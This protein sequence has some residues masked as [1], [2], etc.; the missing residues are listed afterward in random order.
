FLVQSRRG[1]VVVLCYRGTEATNL[2]NWLGDVGIGPET[3]TLDEARL[4]VHAGF[5][6]NVRSTCWTVLEKLTH[7][8]EGSSGG[9]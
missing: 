9:R 7:A 2:G 4:Q 5:Y 8:L 1:R 6:R 3:I